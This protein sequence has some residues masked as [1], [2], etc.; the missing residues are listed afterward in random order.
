MGNNKTIEVNELVY[1]EFE[2]ILALHKKTDTYTRFETVNDLF[3]E[4]TPI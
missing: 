1:K 4:L 2:Y 3:R